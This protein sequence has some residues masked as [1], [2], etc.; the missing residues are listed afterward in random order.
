MNRVINT[1]LLYYY[2]VTHVCIIFIIMYH[3]IATQISAGKL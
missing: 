1:Q 2:T 3:T